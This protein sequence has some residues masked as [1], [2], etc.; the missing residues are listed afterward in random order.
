MAEI[1]AHL[2]T[3]DADFVPPLSSRIEIY[4]YAQK[5]SNKATRFEAWSSSTLIGLVAVYCNDHER[6]VAYITSASV[7]KT[8]AGKGIATQLIDKCIKYAQAS[9]MRQISLEV[10]VNNIPATKLYEKSGFVTDKAGTLFV[11]MNLY[12]NSGEKHEQPA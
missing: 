10:A 11:T 2:T 6:R 8:W 9:G 5:I 7:L 1:A 4:D 12:L 3:V